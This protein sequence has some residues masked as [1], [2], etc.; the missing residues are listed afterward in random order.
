MAPDL[1]YT[2]LKPLEEKYATIQRKG[3][4]SVVFCFLLN[5]VHF[6]HDKTLVTSA[7]S[8]S[9]AAL[10]EILAT[11]ALREYGDNTLD[12]ALVITTSWPVYSGADEELMQQSLDE[13]NLDV[14]DL[15][16]YVGNAIEM[17][18]LGSAKRFIKSPACQK[19]IDSIYRFVTTS[20]DKTGTSCTD[21]MQWQMCIS[22]AKQPCDSI[23]RELT[24][25]LV[26]RSHKS[27]EHPQTYKRTPIHF[28]DPHKAP[29]LDHYR[30]AN[31]RHRTGPDSADR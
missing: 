29:L 26:T 4:C 6:L 3:N 22:S 9:R 17:A 30:Y 10:C 23:R 21:M 31:L 20:L 5:R 18:I 12:L 1:T 13:L 8:R 15:E 19:V 14:E 7:V 27:H 25:G 11:R 2:L 24:H 28:Y 16:H